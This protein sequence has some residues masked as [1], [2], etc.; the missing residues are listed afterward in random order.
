[1]SVAFNSPVEEP[2]I[3]AARRGAVA[4]S[5]QIGGNLLMHAAHPAVQLVG[6]VS[7]AMGNAMQVSEAQTR[8][9]YKMLSTPVPVPPAVSP[10][11]PAVDLR[12]FNRST[13]R[14]SL[15]PEPTATR[16]P[17]AQQLFAAAFTQDPVAVAQGMEG[18]SLEED[19]AL[20]RRRNSVFG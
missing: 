16:T 6:S 2:Q 12:S 7:V 20:A 14:R 9:Q 17:L 19:P 4:K 15:F 1:M 5:F 13:P 10:N 11:S 3:L 8:I 18:E